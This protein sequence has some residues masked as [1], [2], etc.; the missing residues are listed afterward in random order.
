MD[1]LPFLVVAVLSFW[2]IELTQILVDN[3]REQK[4]KV[5]GTG[6]VSTRKYKK[7]KGKKYEII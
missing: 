1:P 5:R 3:L 7:T 6:K 2:L 4:P